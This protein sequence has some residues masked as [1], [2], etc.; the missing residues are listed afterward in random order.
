[1]W[2][3][4]SVQVMT[5]LL[6]ELKHYVHSGFNE[7]GGTEYFS[8]KWKNPS[9][10]PGYEGCHVIRVVTKIGMVPI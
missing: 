3:E 5:W 2:N 1:M 8:V 6:H 4:K 9:V 10:H 7:Y